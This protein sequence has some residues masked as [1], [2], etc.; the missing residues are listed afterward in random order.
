MPLEKGVPEYMELCISSTREGYAT[1]YIPT[2]TTDACS[3]VTSQLPA[4]TSRPSINTRGLYR[5]PPTV[6]N[7]ALRRH[8]AS[9]EMA[10]QSR[11]RDP[12]IP[13]YKNT[14][15]IRRMGLLLHPLPLSRRHVDNLP[16]QAA[17]ATRWRQPK[18][19]DIDPAPEQRFRNRP[20]WLVRRDLRHRARAVGFPGYG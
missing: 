9:L 18:R 8:F 16:M 13:V 15:L 4:W 12:Q 2:S 7:R 10:P 3:I 6:P 1:L 11:E 14:N 5:H 20:G 17:A 19:S